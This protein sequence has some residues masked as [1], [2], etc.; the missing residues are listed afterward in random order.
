MPSVSTRNMKTAPLVSVLT[1]S[2]R[3]LGLEVTRTSLLAQTFTSFEWLVEINCTGKHDF[4]AAMNRMLRRAKGTLVVSIQDYIKAPPDYLQKFWD[5]HL[6]KPTTFFTAPVGKV[7]DLDN[8]KDIRWDWRA[9]SDIATI[10]DDCWEIDSAAAP[11][12]ALKEI[13][14][15]DEYL[16][17]WWSSDN[18]SVGKRAALAGY[19]LELLFTNPSIAYDHDAHQKHPFRGNE[20][21]ERV[22]L[23]MK[24]YEAGLKLT[25]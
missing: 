24:E 5:A 22:S 4:N 17:Q 9:H 20:R 11:L 6:K 14:G 25:L 21:P 23:R 2:V 13:G 18:V 16:D 8:P 1:P 7:D 15:F 3:P 12:S 19:P 10:R